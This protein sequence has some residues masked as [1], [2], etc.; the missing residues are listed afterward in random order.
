ML[1]KPMQ[2]A[3]NRQI[4]AEFYSAYLYLAMSAHFEKTNLRGMAHWMRV[5]YQE[6][7]A[8]GLKIF[9]YLHDREAEVSLTQVDTPK[10]DVET[11]LKAFELALEHER[12]VTAMIG[13]LVDLAAKER[14]HA[15]QVF[16]HWFVN[17]QVEEESTASQIVQQLRLVGNNANGLFMMD[18][19]LGSRSG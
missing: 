6:E 12:E 8:H 10:G 16:L 19:H 7:T 2:Q 15:T 3:L 17:E 9:D 5:Q 18:R 14:D 11:P 1:S 13:E 4:N